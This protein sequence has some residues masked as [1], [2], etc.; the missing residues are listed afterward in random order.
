M[1]FDGAVLAAMRLIN[2]EGSQAVRLVAA[3]TETRRRLERARQ[4]LYLEIE[5]SR[6]HVESLAAART[7]RPP[8]H[9]APHMF[10]P[11]EE[12]D[13]LALSLARANPYSIPNY[14]KAPFRGKC[15]RRQ[16]ASASR[17][18]MIV[19]D[20]DDQRRESQ[21]RQAVSGQ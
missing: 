10:L 17:C 12:G 5:K 18:P 6:V 2:R 21:G 9:P 1:I 20:G 11:L 19:E 3:S 13:P 15:R 14:G 8:M 4:K 7:G 16:P